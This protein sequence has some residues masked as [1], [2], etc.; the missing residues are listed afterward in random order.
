MK[1]AEVRESRPVLKE[2]QI[3]GRKKTRDPSSWSKT[4]VVVTQQY[5]KIRGKVRKQTILGSGCVGLRPPSYPT[6]TH[7]L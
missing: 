2:I 3:K 1:T 4:F 6:P 5:T 7:I